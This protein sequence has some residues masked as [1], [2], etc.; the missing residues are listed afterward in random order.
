[1]NAWRPS[2]KKS[3]TAHRT[4]WCKDPED[5]N[6]LT[7]SSFQTVKHSAHKITRLQFEIVKGTEF[8]ASEIFRPIPVA[9][10]P[11]A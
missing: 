4:A 5:H 8:C 6:T 3:V 11:K 2:K 7:P 10:R 9:A 1:M